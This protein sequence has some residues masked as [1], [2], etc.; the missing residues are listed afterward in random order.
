M[1]QERPVPTRL[2]AV[3]FWLRSRRLIALRRLR[4][5]FDRHLV[6]W[7]ASDELADAPVLSQLR[8]P[9]WTD[10]RHDEFALVAG[11][12]HNLRLAAKAFH[13]VVVPAGA[14]LS[15]WRQLGRPSATRGFVRGREI[16]AGCVVPAIAGGLCQISN[17]LATC[18]SR[19]HF[20]LVE[21]HGHTARVAVAD[22][23]DGSGWIDAT[24]FWN[25]VDL[26]IRAPVAWR[27]ELALEANDLVL[28]LR[29]R[30]AVESLPAE[31]ARRWEAGSAKPP[32]PVA[33]DCLSCGEASCFRHH[34]ARPMRRGRTAWLLDVWTPEFS[35]WLGDRE[36]AADLFL[37][38][39]PR[40]WWH[41]LRGKREGWHALKPQGDARLESAGWTWLRRVGW[42]RRRARQAGRRQ[43]SVID[44][45]RWLAAKYARRLRPEH[46]HLL[47]DQ[48]LLPHLQQAGVLGG[49][50]YDVLATSLP[51]G[52]IERRLDSARQSGNRS[53]GLAATLSDFRAPPA[54]VAAES[55]GLRGA[56][57]IITAHGEVARY[58]RESG[59]REV[60][61]LPWTLPQANANRPMAVP[62]SPLVVFPASALA[63]KGACEL[64]EALRGLHCRLWI[65]GTP[66]DDASLWQGVDAKHVG[67]A[68]G[69]L[70]QADVAVL[71]AHVEHS[72]RALLAALAAGIRVIATPACGLHD[73]PDVT[74]IP[75]GD[76]PAL[77]SALSSAL[78]ERTS[79]KAGASTL[80]C[81]N[82]H[83]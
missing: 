36:S 22:G 76:V 73:L 2:G 27:L 71:P 38:L 72:P 20:E 43:A 19:A 9:L 66:S 57:R 52:E 34:D 53:A 70:A 11:K 25:Y 24:V 23:H 80:S 44:G 26:K 58:W 40:W 41:R 68:S 54:L 30:Q 50:S 83:S 37:P 10:G 18:A 32:R 15:F 21:R 77:R 46:V 12:V 31:P 60:L 28:T 4:N 8:M 13:A 78:L 33:R 56:R 65:L 39:P 3:G 51:M 1:M 6:K 29:S 82:P 59:A 49:R 16:K 55:A 75:A 47:I 7:K 74:T 5:G 67:Y 64:A 69:W 62:D 35:A 63:R 42:L 45:Q 79:R 48:G 81:A 17:A 61:L 14:C